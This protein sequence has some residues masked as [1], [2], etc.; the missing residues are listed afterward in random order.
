MGHGVVSPNTVGV[1]LVVFTK[2][3]GVGFR[4]WKLMTTRNERQSQ[5][6]AVKQRHTVLQLGYISTTDKID[7]TQ[8]HQ[9]YHPKGTEIFALPKN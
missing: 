7:T 4:V 9:K 1:G 5:D 8:H 2:L 3:V 6:N